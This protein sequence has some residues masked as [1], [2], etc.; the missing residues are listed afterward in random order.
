M[1]LLTNK[2]NIAKYNTRAY[3]LFGGFPSEV[4]CITDAIFLIIF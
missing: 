3:R 4:K 1:F 2:L